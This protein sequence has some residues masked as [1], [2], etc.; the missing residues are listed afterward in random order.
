MIIFLAA[1][2]RGFALKEKIKQM[3]IDGAYDVRDLGAAKY[4]QNDDYPDF[5]RMV[6]EQ[7]TLA[8]NDS[9]TDGA[10]GIVICGSGVGADIAANKFAGIRSALAISP[11]HIYTARHDDDVN[12][13]ALAADFIDEAAAQQIVKTFITTPF[14]GEE[15]YVRRIDKI[16]KS[17]KSA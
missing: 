4:D 10:R 14:A 15:R 3:L 7:V 17:E 8:E 9:T 1:D 12:V 2:H 6:A 13:L 5:A 16:A 11:D